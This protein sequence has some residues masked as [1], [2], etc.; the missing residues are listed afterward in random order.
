IDMISKSHKAFGLIFPIYF[1]VEK[2]FYISIVYRPTF[3]NKFAYE[4]LISID[5]AWKIELG[6]IYGKSK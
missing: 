3:S 4:H 1:H 6:N 5:F 2:S